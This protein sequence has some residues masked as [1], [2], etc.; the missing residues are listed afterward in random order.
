VFD[1]T[2]APDVA[3]LP[4]PRKLKEHLKKP[5]PVFAAEPI[6]KPVAAKRPAPRA[7]RR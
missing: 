3:G 7:A 5:A 1:G 4:P 2:P 6:Q